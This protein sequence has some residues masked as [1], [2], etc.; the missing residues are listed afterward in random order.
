ML[1]EIVKRNRIGLGTLSEL[2]EAHVRVVIPVPTIPLYQ[3]LKRNSRRAL[4]YSV[5]AVSAS[6][7]PQN[8]REHRERAE[9]NLSHSALASDLRV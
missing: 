9:T 7:E 6:G 5:S 8:R 2:P 1:S 4:R 3:I